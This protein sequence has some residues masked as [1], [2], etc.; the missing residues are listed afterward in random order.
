[1]NTVTSFFRFFLPLPEIK[2]KVVPLSNKILLVLVICLLALAGCLWPSQEPVGETPA[3]INPQEWEG[4]WVSP[5]NKT[6]TDFM[7]M[8]VVD[9][10]QGILLMKVSEWDEK[11]KREVSETVV[12]YLRQ[13]GDWLFANWKG[14]RDTP[15]AW[16]KIG[17]WATDDGGR[18]IVSWLPG[19]KEVSRLI[20]RGELPG[21]LVGEKDKEQLVLGPLL[22]KHYQVMRDNEQE[23]FFKNEPIVLVRLAKQ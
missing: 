4:T 15:F 1:M 23:I 21:R 12:L 16:V 17:N 7:E 8:E 10:P 18:V 11:K 20:E 13:S 2:R 19:E 14:V 9:A 22:P 5:G 3:S 6:D